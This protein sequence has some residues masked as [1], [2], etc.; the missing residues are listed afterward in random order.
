M[1]VNFRI[2]FERTTDSLGIYIMDQEV[3]VHAFTSNGYDDPGGWARDEVS[4]LKWDE[5]KEFVVAAKID[6]EAE[7]H[8]YELYGTMELESHKC[9]SYF[10][11]EEWDTSRELS[12]IHVQIVNENDR[13]QYEEPQQIN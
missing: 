2:V 11:P 12:N 7:D 4:M 1:T 13:F 10:D 8:V 5:L 9:N 6:P 3:F